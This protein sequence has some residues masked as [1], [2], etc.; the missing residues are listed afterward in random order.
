MKYDNEL[1][2]LS[3]EAYNMVK[4]SNNNINKDIK[5]KQDKLLKLLLIHQFLDNRH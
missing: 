3:I 5:R 4:P 2:N 1:F